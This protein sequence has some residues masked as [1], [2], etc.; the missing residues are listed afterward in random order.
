MCTNSFYLRGAD[1]ALEELPWASPPAVGRVVDHE[2]AL[3]VPES[4]RHSRRSPD[5]LTPVRP[6]PLADLVLLRSA[7]ESVLLLV[8]LLAV[9]LAGHLL[10]LELEDRN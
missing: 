9:H 8:D 6:L 2:K 3:Q 5:R 1:E 4:R 7:L 10:R